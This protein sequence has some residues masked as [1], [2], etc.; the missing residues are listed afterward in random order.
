MATSIHF[1]YT[2]Y[3]LPG[4]ASVNYDP[5]ASLRK[6]LPKYPGLT[7]VEELPKE[8]NAMF[9]RAYLDKDVQRSYAP[10]D[11]K[12][13]KYFGSGLSQDQAEGLQNSTTAYILE[14]AHPKTNVWSALRLANEIVEKIARDSGGLVW[15]EETRQVFSPDAWHQKRLGS[16]LGDIPDVSTQT[17][18]H[19]YPN[20]DFARAIT[21]G[22]SKMGLP[23]IVVQETPWSSDNQ[24]GNLINI[25][26][27]SIAES[28]TPH[29]GDQ[30]KLDL[31]TIKN[32]R[33]RENQLKDLKGNAVA[34]LT[35][36]ETKWEEGDPKNR[37]VR[38][39][40]DQYPG[41]DS[42]ARQDA[43]I[44]SFFGAED[45][46][47]EVKHNQELLDESAKEKSKLPDLRKL[48]NAGLAPGEL[49]EVKAPFSTENGDR[50]WMWV[51]ITNWNGDEIH[52]VLENDPAEVKNLSA[53]QVVQVR[54]DDVFDYI[55]QLPDKRVEGNTTG[56][57]I[58]RM[59][60]ANKERH[61]TPA[62]PVP[63][64]TAD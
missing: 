60:E 46:L 15:D 58:R 61:T 27:Q 23:D 7:I 8:P 45:S 5:A 13:L 9:L 1:Q 50:E 41:N 20:G 6:I 40:S 11:V 30:Y 32:P 16:W 37:L 64:C 12:S 48:F 31:H 57:I 54:Q 52:G 2:V 56:E 63:A 59:S 36:A 18:I 38:L 34:C 33:L 4:V 51:E 39:N 26:S 3:L 28:Q 22:M 21:L 53:G 47:A 29:N 19:I 62:V 17:V 49:I 24:V 25:F 43:M 35:L 55:H 44:S 10:P 42:H 14:F